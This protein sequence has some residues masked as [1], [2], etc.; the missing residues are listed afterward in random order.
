MKHD[1]QYTI[2]FHVNISRLLSKSKVSQHLFQ[3]S[4]KLIIIYFTFM[5]RAYFQNHLNVTPY[6]DFPASIISV[7]AHERENILFINIK[8]F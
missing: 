3:K 1:R 5:N 2:Y 7:Q 8:M 4:C 6:K